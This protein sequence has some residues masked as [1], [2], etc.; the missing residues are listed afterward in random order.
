MGLPVWTPQR[1]KVSYEVV[2][3][4]LDTYLQSA[5]ADETCCLDKKNVIEKQLLKEKLYESRSLSAQLLLA[6]RKTR[7]I[8]SRITLIASF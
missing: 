3:D 2:S 5:L 7:W 6:W 1:R 8:E 4:I